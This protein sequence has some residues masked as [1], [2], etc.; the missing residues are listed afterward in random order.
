MYKYLVMFFVVM[1]TAF[2]IDIIAAEAVLLTCQS[3]GHTLYAQCVVKVPI[4][5]DDIAVCTGLKAS[6]TLC[7]AQLTAPS[8]LIP[9]RDPDPY[10][11]NPFTPCTYEAAHVILYDIC[12]TTPAEL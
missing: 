12:P 10:A 7:L 6:Y 5:P 3:T 11:I 4:T 2:A 8:P 9:A 1:H